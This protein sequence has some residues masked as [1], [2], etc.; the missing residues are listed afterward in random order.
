MQNLVIHHY[1]VTYLKDKILLI[2]LFD[3]S[4]RKS[5]DKQ[6]TKITHRATITM[7]SKMRGLDRENVSYNHGH[8]VNTQSLFRIFSQAFLIPLPEVT[9]L[10]NLR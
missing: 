1:Q 10:L 3:E 7:N 4:T 5:S 2:I 9:V 8:Y 6:P